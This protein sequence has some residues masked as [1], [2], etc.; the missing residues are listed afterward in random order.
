MSKEFAAFPISLKGNVLPA[1]TKNFPLILNLNS[2]SPSA[3]VRPRLSGMSALRRREHEIDH[4]S[5]RGFVRFFS[6]CHPRV[7]IRFS[8]NRNYT[9]GGS[10]GDAAETAPATA[11][12]PT[13]LGRP[14]TAPLPLPPPPPPPPRDGPVRYSATRSVI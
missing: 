10:G 6:N 1:S 9:R 8:T 12:C 3:S 11:A 4:S 2:S 5:F 7:I 13:C 14:P